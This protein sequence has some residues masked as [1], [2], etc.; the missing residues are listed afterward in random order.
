ME[1]KGKIY[2]VLLVRLNAEYK[3]EFPNWEA[4]TILMKLLHK[5]E[6]L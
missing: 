6:R 3:R 4:I 1:E 2:Y 5:I